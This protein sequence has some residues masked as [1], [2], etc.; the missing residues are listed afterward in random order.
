MPRHYLS[1]APASI[2]FALSTAWSTVETLREH[3]WSGC[4]CCAM[5]EASASCCQ[6]YAILARP[7]PI[8]PLIGSIGPCPASSPG[9][10]KPGWLALSTL[11]AKLA[12]AGASSLCCA[13]RAL[14][15]RLLFTSK[16]RRARS[17][18]KVPLIALASPGKVRSALA[19][20]ALLFEAT[21]AFP[22][23]SHHTSCTEIRR[24]RLALVSACGA[25]LLPRLVLVLTLPVPRARLPL[26][27]DRLVAAHSW[28]DHGGQADHR[29]NHGRCRGDW[30]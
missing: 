23:S 1:A 19:G 14:L 3:S 20:R 4:E 29:H 7:I 26:H 28:G 17:R 6:M 13:K 27:P 2:M 22:A 9:W 5:G 21:S 18:T 11:P 15:G 16:L 10:V 24:L 8:V 12:R 25:G 30:P